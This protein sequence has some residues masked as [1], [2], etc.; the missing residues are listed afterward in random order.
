MA[1]TPIQLGQT[2]R[3]A[4]SSPNGQEGLFFKG[5]ISSHVR[6]QRG[7]EEDRIL[8]DEINIQK[9]PELAGKIMAVIDGF[10]G[11][12]AVELVFNSLKDTFEGSLVETCGNIQEAYQK[13]IGILSEKIKA[14]VRDGSGTTLTMVFVPYNQVSEDEFTLRLCHIGDSMFIAKDI[15]GKQFFT[16]IHNCSNEEEK[17]AIS[18]RALQMGKRVSFREY[19]GQTYVVYEEEPIIQLT[20][21]LYNSE[22]IWPIPQIETL[23]FGRE[24][25]FALVTDGIVT[26][27]NKVNVFNQLGNMGVDARLLTNLSCIQDDRA[28][29]VWKAS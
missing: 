17:S 12:E 7:K 20:S 4:I 13:M 28:A 9:C 10:L 27:K 6:P 21:A 15:D 2:T 16:I 22:L 11:K 24:S 1:L 14:K 18:E 8:I 29:I 5:T 26:E 23:T 25:F 19:L 3:V